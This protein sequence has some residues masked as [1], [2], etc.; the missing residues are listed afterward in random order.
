MP[1]LRGYGTGF[2]DLLGQVTTKATGAGRPTY[3]VVNGNFEEYKFAINDRIQLFYH[4]NHDFVPGLVYPHIHLETDGTDTRVI[5]FQGEL[6]YAPG[7]GQG[8]Y[9]YGSPT[10]FTIDQTPNG[11]PYTSYV[12]EYLAGID[13]SAWQVDGGCKI[14]WKRITNGGSENPDG[15][16]VTT[17]DIH[18][19]STASGATTP[20]KAPPFI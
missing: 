12:A 6:V 3:A 4:I 2:T 13:A 15:V 9:N 5:R 7:F 17:A 10:L 20:L 1:N 14:I 19:T 8:S 18:Y 11:T 16:Y